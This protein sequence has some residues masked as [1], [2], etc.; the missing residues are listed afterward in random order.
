MVFSRQAQLLGGKGDG[1]VFYT[2]QLFDF[3][4]HFGGTVGTAQIFQDIYMFFHMLVRHI[5]GTAGQ[6]LAADIAVFY[7]GVALFTG[8]VL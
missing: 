8:T 3:F 7:V 6:T 2:W 4:L 5:A 1:G